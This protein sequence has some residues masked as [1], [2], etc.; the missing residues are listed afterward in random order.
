MPTRPGQR[1]SSLARA[2]SANPISL[3]LAERGDP[4]RPGSPTHGI[5][6]R[7]SASIRARLRARPCG[8]SSK[9]GYHRTPL[10]QAAIEP[11]VIA[12]DPI[13]PDPSHYR[14]VNKAPRFF[15]ALFEFR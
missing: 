12:A 1:D 5:A 9:H 6:H 13:T 2:R 15:W 14:K 10:L 8:S 11:A 4:P 7:C 3:I